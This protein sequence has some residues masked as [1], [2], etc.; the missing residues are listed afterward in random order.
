MIAKALAANHGNRTEAARALGINRNTLR[1][2]IRDLDI[3]LIPSPDSPTQMRLLASVTGS[4]PA[5]SQ[6]GEVVLRD[7]RNEELTIPVYLDLHLRA[8]ANPAIPRGPSCSFPSDSRGNHPDT[9]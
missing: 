2:K 5:G 8:H 4:L 9:A 6:G 3:R 7:A 1:K